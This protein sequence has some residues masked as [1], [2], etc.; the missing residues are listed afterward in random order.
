MIEGYN[1]G[2]TR[3]KFIFTRVFPLIS[4]FVLCLSLYG[5][6]ADEEPSGASIGI[7]DSLPKFSVT[8]SDGSLVDNSTLSGKVGMIVF[9]NTECPDCQK[10]L[11][12][13]QKVWETFKDN[14]DVII[15]PIARE[16]SA[17]Q[18]QQYWSTHDLSMP[19]SPQENRQVYSL[20]AKSIIPRIYIC[21]PQGRIVFIST[22]QNMPSAET[23]IPLIKSLLSEAS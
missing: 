10:E 11:P 18:I 1:L 6:I 17:S 9:F 19:Y 23:L 20:F 8:L 3:A 5:C 22:D 14:S 7:G 12:E 16:E 21:N 15:V 4:L 2:K 13:V